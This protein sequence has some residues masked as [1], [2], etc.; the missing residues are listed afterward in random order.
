M[1]HFG[2][3]DIDLFASRVNNQLPRYVSWNPD[4]F[5]WEVNAMTIDWN[6][7]GIFCFPPFCMISLIL[8]RLRQQKATMVL[9]A[10]QWPQQVWYP[11]LMEMLVEIPFKLPRIPNI[12]SDPATGRIMN[13]AKLKLT[14]FSVSGDNL[15]RENFLRR[16]EK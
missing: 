5:A 16:R 6:M 12:V 1:R 14:A 10:P 9:V 3:C 8:A 2:S 15:K 7:E 11:T 4:P 13:N